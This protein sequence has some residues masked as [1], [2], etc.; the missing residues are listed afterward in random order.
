MGRSVCFLVT[1]YEH[2]VITKF[3]GN[4]LI[5]LLNNGSQFLLCFVDGTADL[6]S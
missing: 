6:A 1:D 3:P 5:F 2:R 4:Q